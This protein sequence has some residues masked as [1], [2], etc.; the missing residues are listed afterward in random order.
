MKAR[1]NTNDSE[2]ERTMLSAELVN[3]FHCDGFGSI[4]GVL[5]GA[6][7]DSLL[8]ELEN[9]LSASPPIAFDQMPAGGVQRY[10]RKRFR[11]L[12]A[13]DCTSLP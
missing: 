5:S 8:A 6:E 11:C 13:E 10:E 4:D 2:S 1:V 12:D 9:A 3:Q 7:L